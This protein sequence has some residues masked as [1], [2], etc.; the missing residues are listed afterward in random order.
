MRGI[1]SRFVK[2]PFYGKMIVAVF[3]LA[4][5]IALATMKKSFFPHTQSKT[6]FVSMVY[7]GASP[8]EVEE[9]ITSRVEEAVR[10]IV[11]IKEINSSSS[12]SFSRVTIT[13]TGDYDLDETLAE[14]KNAVDGIP[15]FP[16]G[17]EKPVVSK[18]R[19]TTQAVFM[20]I[21]GDVDLITLKRYA[22]E[23]YDDL[24]ASQVMSQVSVFGF[25]RLELSVEVGE[26]D[27][28]RYG[29]SFSEISR[30][31]ANNNID[32][33]GGT[34]KN[35]SEEI[36][37]RSRSRSVNPDQ[38]GEIILKANPDGSYLRIREVATIRL[39]FE[40]VPQSSYVNGKP[41][42]TIFIQKLNTE[43]LKVISE[44]CNQYVSEFN[45]SHE[46]VQLEITYDFV[47]MLQSRL[48][49]LYKNGAYGL[50]LVILSL[51]MFLSFRLSLWVAWGIPA[52]FLGMFIVGNLLGITINMISLFG[53]ILIIGILVDD[54]IVIGENIYTHFERGKNPRR[55][56]ID[57]TLE[58]IPAVLTSVT[59]TIVAFSPLLL[60]SGQMEFLYEMAFVVIMCL[61]VSLLESFFVLPSHVG[62]PQVLRTRAK[63]TIFNRIRRKLD[64]AIF[65]V[66]DEVYA[67][68]LVRIVKWRWVVL[69]IPLVFM[70]ITSGL[71]GGG[72]IQ[73][74]FFPNVSFDWFT[75]N[76]AFKPGV[77]K[78]ITIDQLKKFE[79]RIWEVNQEL[80]EKYND[81]IPFV[82]YTILNTGSAFNG[83]ENGTHAGVVMTFLRDLEGAPVNSFQISNLVKDKIGEVKE[84][85]KLTVGGT[86]PWGAPISISLLG[87]DLERLNQ[88]NGFLQEELGK[89]TSLYNITDN[90]PLGSREVRLKLK[91][92]AYFLGLDLRTISSQVR[93][94]FFGGQSQRLQE[95]RDEIKVWVRYP[96]SDRVSI[97]QMEDMR[98]KT[99]MGEFPLS[100]LVEYDIERGPV[101]IQ[102]YNGARE[103]RVDAELLDPTEPVPPIVEEISA[104]VIPVLSERYPGVDVEY[105]GQQKESRDEFKEIT[106]FFS[107]AFLIIMFIV[108]IHFRSFFHGLIVLL[109]VPLGWLG[110]FW[111]HGFEGIPVSMLS[112][113]GM[114][115]L[116]GV[117]IND[118]VVFLS[119]YNSL[120]LEG[121]NVENAVKAA[122]KARF[123]AIILTTITTSAGLYPLILERSVQAQFLIPM[124]VAL[125]YGVLFGT[126]FMLLFFP[127]LILVVNDIRRLMQRTW[128]GRKVEGENLEPIVKESKVSLD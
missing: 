10:G 106:N 17:A 84:A 36:L 127:V 83:L 72:F 35:Q 27:L 19:A 125:A 115:A 16:T 67:R 37:I 92:K 121:L 14:V 111:G 33:S 8:K 41:A 71:V 63:S 24:L 44:Y 64:K 119:K 113:W 42:V 104:K 85:Q 97:G 32:V 22:D 15:T 46:G 60:L 31:I 99:A 45:A 98:I 1:V 26:E 29:L 116:S 96:Q 48:N 77:N 117:I 28:R 59:T 124:A 51:A 57:G 75:V 91:P 80:M 87:K 43:D 88:A 89:M 79:D 90:N 65:Y 52:S 50:A 58:V 30:A 74:T 39:Q 38:I 62:N 21:L 61:A 4:G 13:T 101:S 86:N 55:A 94:G 78:Q 122:G 108:M 82:E 18:Q 3:L 95:G 54:G 123:R 102:R 110:S 100:E 126:M 53:M 114:V 69:F 20:S 25:P 112:M 68:I 9:G 93:Q 66:R 107:I 73:M 120:L 40:D 23:I 34:I 103:I 128:T 6:L 109:M 56:A 7:P 11:G 49:L 5:G 2:Y 105:Q 76:V 70:L 118:S 47:K 81:T 12:E